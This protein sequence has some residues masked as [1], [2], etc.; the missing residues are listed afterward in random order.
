MK[1][2]IYTDLNLISLKNIINKF[3]NRNVEIR[4]LQIN[5]LAWE[6]SII[7]I[8]SHDLSDI[9]FAIFW[10]SRICLIN[11]EIINKK[12]SSN[13]EEFVE[14]IYRRSL[15]NLKTIKSL[16]LETI[17]I[18]PEN[19]YLISQEF[20][21]H[22]LLKSNSR[23]WN[24]FSY[25]FLEN[26]GINIIYETDY[27][28]INHY[29]ERLWYAT[30]NPYCF[31]YMRIIAEQIV[32]SINSVA[33]PI[34]VIAFDLDDT[35]WGGIV[36]ELGFNGIRLGGHDPI[37]ELY[38]D[39]QRVLLNAKS[40]GIILGV[41]S[42]NNKEDALEVFH[43]NS[44]MILKDS[45]LD[46]IYCNWEEKYLNLKY[47]SSELNL[48]IE[49]FA[50]VDNSEIEREKMKSFL[51]SVKTI[52]LPKDPFQWASFLNNILSIKNENTKEDNLRKK[53]YKLERIREYEIKS[54]I[55]E[56][57]NSLEENDIKKIFEVKV[58]E[59]VFDLIRIHQLFSRTN[60]FNLSTQRLNR[61]QISDLNENKD[62]YLKSFSVSD[63]FG[64]YGIC[65]TF[66]AKIYSDRLHIKD[67][68]ISCRALGI[69][70]ENY[71]FNN[72][73]TIAKINNLKSLIFEYRETKK[74]KPIFKF[75]SE[76]NVFQYEG[77]LKFNL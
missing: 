52:N 65:G 57:Q 51:P 37:G 49:N 47:A 50:F 61:E 11:N 60:Q 28:T 14:G 55:K 1:I 24:F 13:N 12:N 42:K 72:L 10:F 45:D 48:S 33:C 36:G 76:K 19:R 3:L 9:N 21:F 64:D 53:H 67:L 62:I 2:L 54:F 68:I 30:K 29:S 69:G 7:N 5:R 34:K 31:E 43:K 77:N 27:L 66:V 20:K 22:D 15:E 4:F 59:E 23:L 58:S 32:N 38:Q 70:L 26:N 56:N 35:I 44:N 46:F 16:G 71:I 63:K 25:K 73:I 8:K 17:F 18:N 41:L 74:N 39:I 75:L 40:N 6:E